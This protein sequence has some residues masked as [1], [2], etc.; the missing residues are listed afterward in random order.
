VEQWKKC[1][2]GVIRESKHERSV[3]RSLRWKDFSFQEK[4]PTALEGRFEVGCGRSNAEKDVLV[5]SKMSVM[6]L[7]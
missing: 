2:E 3:E 1:R 7:D 5:L 4:I 6:K